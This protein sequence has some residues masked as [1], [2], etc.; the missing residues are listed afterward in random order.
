MALTKGDLQAIGKMMSEKMDARFDEQDKNFDKRFKI[1]FSDNVLGKI[2]RGQINNALEDVVFPRFDS[3]EKKFDDLGKK[4]DRNAKKI[5]RNAGKI[6]KLDMKVGGINR[7]L[8][9]LNDHWADKLD[10][11]EERIDRLETKLGVGV[12]I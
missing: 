7:R 6:E 2:I 8:D 4:V 5:D 3:L 1:A 10:D 9:K 12:T 11:H